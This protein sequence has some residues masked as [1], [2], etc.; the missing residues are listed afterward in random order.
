MNIIIKGALYINEESNIVVK[1]LSKTGEHD[2]I[3]AEVYVNEELADKYGRKTQAYLD[4][5]EDVEDIIAVLEYQR[6]GEKGVPAEE[7][8]ER[9]RKEREN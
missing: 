7:A 1:S 5:L 9:I 6:S 2:Q 3:E 8:F 4:E